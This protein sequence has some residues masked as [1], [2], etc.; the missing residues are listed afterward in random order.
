VDTYTLTY[1]GSARLLTDLVQDLQD[2]DIAV[3]YRPPLETKDLGA[4]MEVANVLIAVSGGLPRLMD[5]A[6]RWLR[7]HPDTQLDGLPQYPAPTVQERLGKLADLRDSAV[8]TEDE[9]QRER[10]RILGEI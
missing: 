2:N 4:V 10:Q 1:R 8:I 6:D 7:K 3:S 9:Y 5:V